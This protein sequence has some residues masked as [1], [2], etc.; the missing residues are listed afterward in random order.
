MTPDYKYKGVSETYR[1]RVERLFGVGT[2]L[3]GFLLD[4]MPSDRS[5]RLAAAVSKAMIE[6]AWQNERSKK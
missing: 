4:R 5:G 6:V 2:P 1:E 3:A